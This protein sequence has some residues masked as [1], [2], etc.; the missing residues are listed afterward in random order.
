[1]TEGIDLVHQFF[2]GTGSSYDHIVN[3]CTI[4][5]D[6]CWKKRILAKIPRGATRILD[7]ACGTGILTL[8]IARKFPNAFILGVDITDEYLAIA[9][10]KAARMEI[11]NVRFISGR[12]EDVRLDQGFDCI[13]SSY[14]AKYAEMDR[15]IKNIRSMLSPGGV[16]ILH[17]FTYPS[18]PVYAWAWELHFKLLQA[19]GSR[20]YPQWKSVFYG[21]PTLLRDTRWVVELKRCLQSEGFSNISLEY[22]TFGTSAIITAIKV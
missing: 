5:F 13:T 17:D 3:L 15:L 12:A 22:L 2:P 6:R 20:M 18:N 19:A 9:R 7:Q 1:M 8:K 16:S 11:N 21:L 4:G 10:E 14:L